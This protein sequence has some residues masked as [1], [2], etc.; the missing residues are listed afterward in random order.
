MWNESWGFNIDTVKGLA[1]DDIT[2]QNKSDVELQ[3]LLSIVGINLNI[4]KTLLTLLHFIVYVWF[5]CL[6]TDL[7]KINP[8]KNRSQLCVCVCVVALRS[9]VPALLS[10]FKL[11]AIFHLPPRVA[12][13]PAL[14]FNMRC[15]LIIKGMYLNYK[16]TSYTEVGKAGT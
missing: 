2:E 14:C 10:N 12:R 1:T 3:K 9:F 8:P 5:L 11:N 6:E 4:E 15:W 13:C 7:K 16:Y